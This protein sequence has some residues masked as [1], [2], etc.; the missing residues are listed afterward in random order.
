MSREIPTGSRVAHAVLSTV[1]A[2]ATRAGKAVSTWKKRGLPAH[3]MKGMFIVFFRTAKFTAHIVLSGLL[4]KEAA[5]SKLTMNFYQAFP[6]WRYRYHNKRA[7]RRLNFAFGIC[8]EAKLK[9][10]SARERDGE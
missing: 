5:R 2:L 8:S 1:A 4:K 3:S 9:Y 10:A 7:T 6:V